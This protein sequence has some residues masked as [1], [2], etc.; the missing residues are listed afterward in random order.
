MT[1]N[2]DYPD[3]VS[4]IS[5]LGVA[6]LEDV[7]NLLDEASASSGIE[8]SDRVNATVFTRTIMRL[9]REALNSID[10]AEE[11]V[12]VMDIS[13]IVIMSARYQANLDS[14][15]SKIYFDLRM[16]TGTQ[17]LRAVGEALKHPLLKYGWNFLD[18]L[19][20]LRSTK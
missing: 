18:R 10:L 12:D 9:T 5:D 15:F 7:A 13:M 11:I 17:D 16:D 6:D 2:A 3:D 19:A 20:S 4:E 8:V 1:G 14:L